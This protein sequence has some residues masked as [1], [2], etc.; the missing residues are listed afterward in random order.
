[1]SRYAQNTDVTVGRSRDEIEK[2]L[3]RYG[4]SQF[5]YGWDQQQALIG[6]VANDRQIKMM[7]TLPDKQD[8]AFTQ[9][10]GGRYMREPADALKAWEKACRQSWRALALVVKAKLEAV[11]SGIATFED[12]FLAYTV[13]PGGQTVAQLVAPHIAESYL[14]GS[15][16]PF[17]A[18]LGD[19]S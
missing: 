11:E 8:R 4:A 15:V 12:E 6:F 3:A 14:G 17:L 9:T 19:G 10:P 7:L 16:A 18:A 2:T 5:V 1:M 13:L